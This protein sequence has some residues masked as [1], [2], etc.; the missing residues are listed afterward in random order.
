MCVRTYVLSSCVCVVSFLFVNQQ[1]GK[2]G[3]LNTQQTFHN[4]HEYSIP[5]SPTSW[6]GQNAAAMREL[7][8]VGTVRT[9]RPHS[10]ACALLSIRSTGRTC[11]F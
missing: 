4:Q 3:R 7:G 10:T 6:S 5:V 9:W 1:H 2:N 11:E 8:A